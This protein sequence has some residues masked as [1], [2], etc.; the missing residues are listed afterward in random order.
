MFARFLGVSNFSSNAFNAS[1]KAPRHN[2]DKFAEASDRHLES[3]TVCEDPLTAML[4]GC[5]G[6]LLWSLTAILLARLCGPQT[7]NL[8]QPGPVFH[9]SLRFFGRDSWC[10]HRE[11]IPQS[12]ECRSNRRRF[13]GYHVA[14]L[15]LIFG[16]LI[17]Q[18][19]DSTCLLADQQLTST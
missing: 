11:G 9:P 18:S 5:G 7:C 6:G 12:V 15:G 13:W 17:D 1:C 19:Q 10:R 2:P 16:R 4:V 14:K 8:Q 3:P